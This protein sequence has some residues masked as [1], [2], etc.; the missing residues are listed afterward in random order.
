MEIIAV[1]LVLAKCNKWQDKKKDIEDVFHTQ[2]N[3]NSLQLLLTRSTQPTTS[4]LYSK[5]L[6][7]MLLINIHNLSPV[8]ACSRIKPN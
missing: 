6:I 7:L 4:K 5:K 2:V 1:V 8:S 3:E